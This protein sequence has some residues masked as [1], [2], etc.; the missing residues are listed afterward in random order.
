MEQCMAFPV[1]PGQRDAL[2]EFASK[3]MGE[4]RAEFDNSQVTVS[5]EQWYI[6][7]TPLGD[8][9]VVRV[10]AA[11]PMAVFE[12]L[13]SSTEPFDVWFREQ[14]Q[15]TTGVDLRNTPSELPVCIFDW[16]RS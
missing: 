13:A 12:G 2:I 7:S 3:L 15:A 1:L 9:C 14:V 10:E 16:K 8:L 11:D 5:K 6:Q 4:R